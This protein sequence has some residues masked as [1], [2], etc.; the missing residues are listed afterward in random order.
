MLYDRIVRAV[1]MVELKDVCLLLPLIM[2]KA[3]LQYAALSAAVIFIQDEMR[4]T[5]ADC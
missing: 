4:A 1:Q 5:I 3:T 2:E